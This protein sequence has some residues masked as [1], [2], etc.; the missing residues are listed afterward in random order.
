MTRY[1]TMDSPLGV[2]LLVAD[3]DG[4]LTA[5]LAPD[6]KGQVNRPD[7]A[8][9]EDPAPFAAAV[10]Q[11]TAY[12]E[13]ELEEFDLPLAPRGSEFRRQVWDALDGIPYGSTVSYGALAAAAG[14]SPTA[15]RAVAGAI[16]AN[17]LLIVRPCHRVVGANGA[18][19][20]FAAGL[21]AKRLLLRLES[22][23]TALFS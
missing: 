19:T 5:V 4:A 3:E 7:P 11:L 21:D 9:T 1:T 6:T 15:V 17:P 20:G 23:D 12:F 18:L 22:A 10:E 8:W 13:G 14:Q 16:G 2:L